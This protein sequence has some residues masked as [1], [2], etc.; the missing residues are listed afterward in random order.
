MPYVSSATY[1]PGLSMTYSP[2]APRQKKMS[3][4]QSLQ[5]QE[6]AITM[7]QSRFYCPF[8]PCSAAT[9]LTHLRISHMN[10]SVTAPMKKARAK[11]IN[12]MVKYKVQDPLS[13][14]K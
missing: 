9:F 2:D 11:S 7:L 3:A 12:G 4:N 10:V 5:H 1:W 6:F 8:R 13:R 14:A